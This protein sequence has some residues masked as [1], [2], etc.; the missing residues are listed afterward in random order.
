MSHRSK[1][2]EDES[3]SWM[4]V[5]AECGGDWVEEAVSER[6]LKYT[7]RVVGIRLEV[8]NG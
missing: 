6:K 1:I 4:E 2:L 3:M 7:L 5:R 8:R